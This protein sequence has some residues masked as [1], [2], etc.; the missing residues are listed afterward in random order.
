MRTIGITGGIGAGKSLVLSYIKE[1]Y[2]AVVYEADQIAHLIKEPGQKCYEPLVELLGRK[3]L[4]EDGYI[5]KAKMAKMIFG[6]DSLLQEVNAIIHPGVKEFVLAKIQEEEQR[7]ETDFFILEA[8]L[9]IE[10]EYDKILDEIWYVRAEEEVRRKRLKAT[11]GYTEE[12]IE[13]IM[14]SQ[15]QDEMFTKHCSLVIDN[16]GDLAQTYLQ[17]DRKLGEYISAESR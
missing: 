1:H 17:I 5:D 14:K 10:E 15:L 8:A 6:D 13:Q 3:V 4:Q 16:N 9:L 11:R 7:K 2:R 12:K